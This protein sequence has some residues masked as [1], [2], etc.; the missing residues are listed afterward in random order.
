MYADD[1]KLYHRITSQSDA[2]ALQAD[3]DRLSS[4]SLT[5]R[6]NP[7]PAKCHIITF[8]LRKS[9]IIT[10]YTLDGAV[11]Q[12]RTETRYLGVVLDTKLTFAS[13]IDSTVAKANRMLGL[14]IRS[15]QLSKR[16]SRARFDHRAMLSAFCAHVRATIEYGS[17]VWGGAAVTHLKRLE[18]VQ[19]KFLL[20]LARNSDRPSD[21]LEY[22][23]LLSHFSLPSIKSRF[24]Q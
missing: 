1:I 19:H 5:W 17:V 8:S 20:W 7:N 22:R 13:H 14:V 4:W 6:L 23:A 12:R 21:D 15:M 24:G 2:A 10:A 3:I 18:R 9:P 11:L 16:H